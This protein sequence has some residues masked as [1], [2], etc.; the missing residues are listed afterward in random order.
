MRPVLQHLLRDVQLPAEVTRMLVGLSQVDG[1]SM[2]LSA[3]PFLDEET[4][5]ALYPAKPV[6]PVEVAS[7]LCRR[8]LNAAQR[9][10]VLAVEKRSAPLVTF[11]RFNVLAADEQRALAERRKISPALFE[12][13]VTQRWA[14]PNLVRP[15]VFACKGQPML[16]WVA[17]APPGA[18]G[19]DELMNLLVDFSS[20]GPT[21][22]SAATG[23]RRNSALRRLFHT[24]P[25]A[26]EVLEADTVDENLLTPA[27]GCRFLT[28]DG[29]RYIA[30]LR[31]EPLT[32]QLVSSRS[33]ALLALVNNPTVDDEVL[34]ALDEHFRGTGG[35]LA[36]TICNAVAR[37]RE[38]NHRAVS[39]RYEEIDDP[40]I[41]RRLVF[42]A[43]PASYDGE[44]AR[45]KSFDALALARNPHLGA[46][47]A[48]IGEWLRMDHSPARTDVRVEERLAAAEVFAANYPT[49]KT[50][51][52]VRAHREASERAKART[53]ASVPASTHGVAPQT[54]LDQPTITPEEV[55]RWKGVV[56]TTTELRSRI[57]PVA[58]PVTH[59]GIATA[60]FEHIYERFGADSRSWELLFSLD[61]AVTGPLGDLLSTVAAIAA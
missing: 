53:T 48:R 36:F 21:T 16:D 19:D 39:P 26:L 14:D 13:F 23:A 10:H 1:V 46:Y 37:R 35:Q 57:G 30:G 49:D 52:W 31:G 61:E 51:R 42:R 5:T 55:Q 38:R 4:W 29:A 9:A 25:V 60:A 43:L 17:T 44:R 40:E 6:P 7:N 3:N 56:L 24:R 22:D 2:A 28:A 12:T 20:W 32:H 8:R 34:N 54:A 58:V 33:F 27:A 15:L 18:L 45:Y 50:A 47:A 11:L 59:M 41:L